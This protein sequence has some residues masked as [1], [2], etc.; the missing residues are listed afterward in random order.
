MIFNIDPKVDYA[1]KHLFGKE[2]T[3][4]ILIDLLNQILSGDGKR[5]I[6]EVELLDPFNP[7]ETFDDKL[8]I[9][10]IKARDD[11]GRQ[12]NVEMQ[13]LPHSYFKSRILYYLAKLHQQQLHKG[14]KYSVLK[15]S[16]SIVFVDNVLFPEVADYH[17]RFRLLE[18]RHHLLFAD[19]LEVYT[20]ELPKFHKRDVELLDGLDIWLYFLRYAAK[21]DSDALPKALDHPLVL[22]AMEELKMIAQSDI[23]RERYEARR[24]AQMDY[25]TG[26]EEARMQGE[27]TGLAKGMKIGV[28]Q[29]CEGLLQFS[30]TSREH[31]EKLSLEELTRLADELR[32]QVMNKK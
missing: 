15:P 21:I 32:T 27:A 26:M 29:Y 22:Q 16:I 3:R 9:L 24:K 31:L 13:M 11:S 1:F 5:V 23:E 30:T 17:L 4:P 6:R 12:I 14:E 25:D 8:S 19:D 10:D 7:K 18:E 20:L 2:S 28:I